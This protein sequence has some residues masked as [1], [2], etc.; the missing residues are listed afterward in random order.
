ME[1]GKDELDRA[2]RGDAAALARLVAVLTPVVQLRVVRALN[3]RSAKA[4]GRRVRQEVEDMTQ[5]VFVALFDRDGKKLRAWDPARGLTLTAFVGYLAERE[6]VSRLRRGRSSPWT[7][8]PT[9]AELLEE[10]GAEN[11]APLDARLA[12]REMLDEVLERLREELTPQGRD[13]FRALFLDEHSV[14]EICAS[15]GMRRD[16]VY[17][18]RS[19]L[20]RRVRAVGE[21]LGA[22]PAGR[23]TGGA[24]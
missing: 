16:A 15:S 24:S 2:L 21:E 22:L 17:A 3:R 10:A 4:V 7:E 20:L 13:M 23:K 8:D 14:E 9:E 19:R 11:D 12:S 5:N 18:W 6:V 1:L